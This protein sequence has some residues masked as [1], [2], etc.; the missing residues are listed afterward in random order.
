MMSDD[1]RWMEENLLILAEQHIDIRHLLFEKFLAAFP[2]RRVAFLNLDAASRRMTDETLQMLFG[3][4]QGED[5]VWSMVAELVAT[6]RNYGALPIE[7]YDIFIDMVVTEISQACDGAWTV[8]HSEAWDRQAKALK[9]LVRKAT[10][11]WD[12]VMRPQRPDA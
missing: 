11:D 8:M 4:A 6:H 12:Q 2:H 1:A 7:E 3:L 10:Q 5:W 9:Q